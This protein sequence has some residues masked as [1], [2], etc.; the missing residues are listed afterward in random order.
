MKKL[1][2]LSPLTIS[3]FDLDPALV[4]ANNAPMKF[5]LLTKICLALLIAS[6]PAAEKPNILFIFAD[7]Q[8][9]D[10]IH[11][12][13][14]SEIETPNIDRLVKRGT[15]FTHASNQGSWS[16][17]VC[18]A[19]RTML[20]TG[21]YVWHADKIYGKTDKL[22]RETGKMWPQILE[23]KGGYDTYF[24][25]K[26]HVQANAEK[27][28]KTARHIRPG[29]PNQTK[30]GYNRPIDGQPDPWNPSD[31]KFGGF[32]EGGKHWSEV[33]GDDGVEYLE[34]AAKS[35]AP[36]FMYLAF[37]APHDPRQSPKEY[38]DKY[39]LD[40]ISLPQPF[41]PEYPYKE[42]MAA[43]KGLRDEKLAPFPRTENAVKVNRQEYY[44]IITHMDTQ[45]G[46]I[47]DALEKTGKAD[48]TWIIFTADHGLACGHHGLMGKQN[49]YDHSVRVPWVIV[50]P[51]V[52]AGKRIDTPIY[53]QDAMAT[54]FEI[55]G[56]A[57]PEHV[58]FTSVLPLLKD[59]A[60]PH[61]DAI[62]GAYLKNQR[63]VVFE[64][65]KLILYPTAKVAR[66]YDLKNDPLEIKD[67]AANDGSKPLMKKLFARFLELQKNVGDELDVK[68]AYP[69]LMQY[70]EPPPQTR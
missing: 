26:W 32:W 36:F 60:K 68:S 45:I 20:L 19:S 8:A 70:A 46:R 50:G 53:L 41:L 44:A 63:S 58:E 30:T 33:L 25:G 12:L 3:A 10:T 9:Y 18:V 59:G 11:S 31:P 64:G 62:Y 13:G 55:A 57:K 67:I 16:G 7:D 48:N 42:P 52:E 34:T 35:D 5:R 22:F 51:G 69:E 1:P 39:P 21:R 43:G 24:S 65:H 15:T 4:S 61:H 66:L 6:A 2:N 23:K 29:M 56:I 54:S 14:N 47:L 40:K 27:T 38:V 37:N 17:A 49:M 28:F